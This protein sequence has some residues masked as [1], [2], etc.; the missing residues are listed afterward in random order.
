MDLMTVHAVL[1]SDVTLKKLAKIETNLASVL[2]AE[3]RKHLLETDALSNSIAKAAVRDAIF[4]LAWARLLAT[5]ESAFSRARANIE[6]A[7]VAASNA[8]ERAVTRRS[9]NVATAA[10][11][12]ATAASV[13]RDSD[14]DTQNRTDGEIRAAVRHLETENTH[15]REE[16]QQLR[17]TIEK[18]EEECG[19][20]RAVEFEPE[21]NGVDRD[22]F[23]A[24]RVHKRVAEIVYEEAERENLSIDAY[25]SRLIAKVISPTADYIGQKEPFEREEYLLPPSYKRK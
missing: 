18:L 5:C 13:D 8:S 14:A 3:L 19:G 7:T 1:S 24:F 9:R 17:R 25:G 20:R 4:G 23:L 6:S 10:I 22:A 16:N 15:L 2:E 21:W 11:C 12:D